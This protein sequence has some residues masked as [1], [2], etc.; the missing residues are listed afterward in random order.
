MRVG[1]QCAAMYN[2]HEGNI[3][4]ATWSI[5]GDESLSVYLVCGGCLGPELNQF[6]DHD[7]QEVKAYSLYNSMGGLT[8]EGER[9]L[10]QIKLDSDNAKAERDE[11]QSIGGTG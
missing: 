6:R 8:E 7:M 1:F 3:E 11:R 9:I 2:E 4:G 5:H 10:G